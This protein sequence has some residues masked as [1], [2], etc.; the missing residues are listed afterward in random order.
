MWMNE[1]FFGYDPVGDYAIHILVNNCTV[2]LAGVVDNE[3][4]KRSENREGALLTDVQAV[5]N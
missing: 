3:G 1:P 5:R 4:D 2:T